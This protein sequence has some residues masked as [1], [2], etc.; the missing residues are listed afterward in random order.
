[1]LTM[2]ELKMLDRQS[3]DASDKLGQL[4]SLGVALLHE[5]EIKNVKMR[6]YR[7]N[8]KVKIHARLNR[9]KEMCRHQWKCAD[10]RVFKYQLNEYDQNQRILQLEDR[11]ERQQDEINN[12]ANICEQ[13]RHQ[14]KSIIGSYEQRMNEIEK[15]LKTII[16]GIQ[17]ENK[18]KIS[19]SFSIGDHS[20][21]LSQTP[22][23]IQNV[24]NKYIINNHHGYYNQQASSLGSGTQGSRPA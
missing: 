21:L 5:N 12:Q 19:N 9:Y 17:E 7:Q 15:V 1:M 8:L 18:A 11:I 2:E 10:S 20:M 22:V 4:K 6:Q 23:V 24:R 13:F 14:R 16:K 3:T